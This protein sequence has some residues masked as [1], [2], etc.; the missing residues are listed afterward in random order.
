ML[1]F[2]TY[3]NQGA[4]VLLT[5]LLDYLLAMANAT[6]GGIISGDFCNCDATAVAASGT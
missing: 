2:P 6:N 5:E 3:A 4:R 1:L